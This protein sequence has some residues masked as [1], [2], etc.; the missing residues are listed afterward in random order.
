VIYLDSSAVLKL[1]TAEAES[2][3]LEDWLVERRDLSVVSSALTQVEV[4]RACRRIDESLLP[5]ARR[6]L[7]GIDLLPIDAS[8]L[9]AAAELPT[10]VPRSLDALHLASAL[11]LDPD[12]ETFV[13]YDARLV[14]AAGAVGLAVAQPGM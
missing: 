8:I 11:S 10:R 12:L 13:A 4:L 7:R 2:D 6:L 9:D 5:G 1:V 14:T 3:A